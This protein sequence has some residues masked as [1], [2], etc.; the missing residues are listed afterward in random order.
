MGHPKNYMRIAS[1]DAGILVEFDAGRVLMGC[2]HRADYH[3]YTSIL[4]GRAFKDTR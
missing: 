1:S 4:E 3:P 2:A